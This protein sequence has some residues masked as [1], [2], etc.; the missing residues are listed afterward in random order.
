MASLELKNLTKK[1]GAFTAV[2]RINLTV[3]DG[4]MVALLGGS[5]CGKT[6]ILNL[7]AGFTDRYEGSILVEGREMNHIPA[8]RRN[9]GVFFQNYALFPHMNTFDNIAFG[10]KMQKLARNLIKE[11]VVKIL[12]L[13]KLTGMGQRYPREL[14]GGQQQRVALARA[15]VTTPTILLL[16]EPLSN[17][18]AKLRVE[19]QLEIKRIHRELGLTTIMVTHDQEEAISL[20]DRVIVMNA[21]RILQV[22]RPKEVFDHPANLFVGDFMGFAN[23]IIGTV[24][25][26][27]GPK[28]KVICSGRELS[29]TGVASD[30]FACGENV[31]LSIRPENISVTKENSENTLTGIVKNVTYKG[32]VTRLEVGGIF[33]ETVF[34]NIHDNKGYEVGEAITVAFPSHKLLIY[35][36]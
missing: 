31:T 24:Q 6:T 7:I 32:T 1:Y 34:V 29:V 23:F 19:M 35:K 18:D 25:Q 2:D 10:L 13:V 33:A 21:G 20:A 11:K 5:G 12:E 9:M 28:V 30:G 16:D 26:L 14:S 27:D 22:G 3:K 8:Y 17:L 36:N 4:E 15:L